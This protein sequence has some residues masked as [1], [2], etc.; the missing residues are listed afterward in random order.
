[1]NC[2]SL[3]RHS[4][5]SLSSSV[6]G[7]WPIGKTPRNCL[8]ALP[9]AAAARPGRAKLSAPDAS[10]CR[11]SLLSDRAIAM[12]SPLSVDALQHAIQSVM[13]Y[14]I[15]ESRFCRRVDV[16]VLIDA[17]SMPLVRS[18]GQV[19]R[20]R[21]LKPVGVRQREFQMEMHG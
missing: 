11:N 18:V 7:V 15:P 20:M 19:R 4:R 14:R 21:H 13:I 8:P 2:T 3:A 12:P 1:Q 17:E 10:V 6:K 9:A 16:T 5:S